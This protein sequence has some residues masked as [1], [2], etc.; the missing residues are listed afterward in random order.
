MARGGE[1]CARPR[2]CAGPRSSTRPA[3]SAATRAAPPASRRTRSRSASTH[4]RQVR[5]RRPLPAGAARVPGHALQPVRGAAVR[6]RVPDR[7]D[8]PAAG[9]DRR[10]RQGRLHRL[11]G[12]HR[13]L[14][15]RRD[16]HQPRG[17]LGREVQLLRAAARRRARAGVRRRLPDRGDR[18]RRP[19]RRRPRACR[20][21]LA[22][23]SSPCAGPRRTTKPKLFYKGAHQA[24]L[25]P[26][27]ARRPPGGLFL[28]SEQS[29]G[30]QQVDS[31]HPGAPNNAAAAM[32]AYDVP[33]SAPWDFRVSL[34]TWTKG[35]AA[36]AYLL[37][38]LLLARRPARRVERALALGG[39][40]RRRRLPRGDRRPAD[41]RPH[42]PRALL[43]GPHAAAVA[44]LARARRR[45]PLALRRR[46]GG[47]LPG[48]ARPDATTGRGRSSGLGVPLAVLSAVYTAWLF[49]QAKARDLWQSPLLPPQLLVQAAPSGAAAL[50]PIAAAARARRAR[51]LARLAAAA[52]RAPPA[53]GRRRGHDRPRHRPRAARRPRDDERA[54]PLVLPLGHRAPGRG[55]L[56]ALGGA[57]APARHARDPRRPAR[58]RARVRS[59][60]PVR[61][62]RLGAS[63]S[64]PKS[65]RVSA[66]RSD[67]ESRG[68]TFY[69]G[70]SRTAL[71]AYPPRER[72]D[73]WV[74][75]DSRRLA[76]S[77]RAPLHARADDLLQLRVGLRAARLR[78]PRD[79]RGPE[80]RGQPRAPGLA[81]PQLR[82]GPGDAQ[83]G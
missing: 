19:E 71:G 34:Y 23:T 58:L 61:A 28:W 42:A 35:I 46:A 1:P 3:A 59:G 22:A 13:R 11:Q 33:H 32:L 40:G 38:A 48:G 50:L 29:P 79:A 20:R 69:P 65:D 41:R 6:L 18:G 14:P 24:T 47:A 31:G 44:E 55:V 5:R 56:A 21:P 30:R 68:E 57:R 7:G 66:S 36:G 9:R 4:L 49:A 63:M 83:P 8:A 37:P 82:Q 64:E 39:A 53:A 70:P 17:P 80:V 16:L 76:A 77:R 60:R 81:R 26:I 54:L 67:T 73:D 52:T 25:D 74:E 51:P 78:G 15:L 27:A 2:P 75:L 72:W 12:L 43:P 10:L 45:D 62:P